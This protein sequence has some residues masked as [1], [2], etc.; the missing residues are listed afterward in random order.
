MSAS[1]T[2][3]RQLLANLRLTFFL[4]VGATGLVVGYALIQDE[5]AHWEIVVFLAIGMV[6]SS[7]INAIF[8]FRRNRSEGET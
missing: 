3:L 4:L 1:T 5:E 6:L 8:D 2:F 7:V